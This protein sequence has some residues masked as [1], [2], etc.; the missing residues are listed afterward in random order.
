M[1][2]REERDF[3]LRLDVRCEFP[4]SYEGDEDGYA[5]WRQF[6]DRVLPDLVR[7]VVAAIRRHPGW[8]VHPANRGR[9]PED[10]L[11]LVVERR[12]G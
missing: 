9:S 6:H 10:E 8:S 7:A 1:P 5:W 11:T 3:T 2:Y 12:P 4:E